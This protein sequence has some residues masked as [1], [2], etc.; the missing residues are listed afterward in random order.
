MV[1][2]GYFCI[3]CID[4]ESFESYLHVDADLAGVVRV[5]IQVIA[6]KRVATRIVAPGAAP[7]RRTSARFSVW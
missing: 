6:G 3:V 2:Y 1:K 7:A 4:L 5:D